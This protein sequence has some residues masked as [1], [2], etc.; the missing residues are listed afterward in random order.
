MDQSQ[1]QESNSSVA[2]SIGTFLNTEV[3]FFIICVIIVISGGFYCWFFRQKK[4]YTQVQIR[5]KS[6]PPYKEY[7]VKVAFD[8]LD[9][10]FIDG[11]S[12]IVMSLYDNRGMFLNKISLP[13]K[14][15][16]RKDRTEGGKKVQDYQM[17][18]LTPERMTPIA[19]IYIMTCAF[20]HEASAFIHSLSIIDKE[21][22]VT[23]SG[24]TYK[25]I[26][27]ENPVSTRAPDFEYPFIHQE[28]KK[29][30]KHPFCF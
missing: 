29:G 13:L 22:N 23:Y 21:A 1:I 18:Y 10:S 7:Q 9:P 20:Y 28:E 6:D 26:A 24:N 14:L 25:R 4:I 17:K 11:T 30:L 2:V 5:R 16:T 12:R 3:Y 19:K 8:S 15:M 27:E